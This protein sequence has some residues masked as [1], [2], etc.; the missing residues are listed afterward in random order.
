MDFVGRF[1]LARSRTGLGGGLGVWVDCIGGSAAA[2][3]SPVFD[4][5]SVYFCGKNVIGY[6]VCLV[7][8]SPLPGG[9]FADLV[10]VAYPEKKA[11]L[12]VTGTAGSSAVSQSKI[13]VNL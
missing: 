10:G 3:A 5:G 12:L 2:L 9:L 8:F 13:R 7:G 1:D 11:F 6:D 4:S